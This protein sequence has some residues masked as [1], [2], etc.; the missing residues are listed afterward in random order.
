MS[1]IYRPYKNPD[2]IELDRYNNW[3]NVIIPNGVNYRIVE[4]QLF[5][6]PPEKQPGWTI[7]LSGFF[8]GFGL[9][10]ILIRVWG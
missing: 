7:L 2:L 9:A 5:I 3:G 4:G 6:Y 1:E 10:M 8:V